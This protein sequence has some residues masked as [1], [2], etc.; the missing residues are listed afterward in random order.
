MKPSSH[1]VSSF[2]AWWTVGCSCF[3]MATHLCGQP[4]EQRIKS[5]GNFNQSSASPRARLL[6][7]TNGLLYGTTE[8]GGWEI[9]GT[10]NFSGSESG[11]VFVVSTNGTGYSV[12]HAFGPTLSDGQYPYGGL[13][14]A[15]DGNLY[16][17]TFGGGYAFHGYLGTV[18]KLDLDGTGYVV[19]YDFGT[20]I[21][22]G[23]NPTAGLVQATNGVLYGTTSTGVPNIFEIE[24]SGSNFSVASSPNVSTLTSPVAIG[25]DGMLYG[26]S[27][28]SGAGPETGYTGILFKVNPD[29]TDFTAL[30]NFTGPDGTT[31]S[32]GLLQGA[33]GSFYGIA[34]SGGSNNVGTVFQVASDG[35]SFS[36]LHVFGG[37]G[38]GQNPYGALLQ[39]LNGRLYGTTGFG[40]A[41]NMGT[42]FELTTNGTGYTVLHNFGGNSDGQNSFAG[43]TQGSDGTLYGTTFAG[44]SGGKGTVFKLSPDGN[45]YSVICDFDPGDFD[46]QFPVAALVQATNGS[47]Y[48][49]TDGGG[50]NNVGTLFR[51]DSYGANYTP[52]HNFSATGQDG[53]SPCGAMLQGADGKLY[54][55]TSAGG[56][57]NGGTAFSVEPDGS[58]YVIIYSFGNGITDGQLPMAGMIQASNGVLYG[59]CASG[60]TNGYG[61]VFEMNPDGTD[62]TILHSFAS[63]GD[64]QSPFCALALGTNGALY[65]TTVYGG[66]N[67]EG[68]IFKISLDGTGYELLYSF[69]A[70][71][72]DAP[73]PNAGLILGNDG[74]FYGTCYGGGVDS[75]SG[76]MVFRISE[77][78]S[79]YAILHTF[80]IGGNGTIILADGLYPMGALAQGNDGALYGTTQLGGAYYNGSTTAGYGTL[81]KLNPDGSQYQLLY[82]FSPGGDATCPYAGL[83]LGTNGDFYGAGMYG[84]DDGLGALFTWG[85]NALPSPELKRPTAANGVVSLSWTST[86]GRAYQTQYKTD[87]RQSYWINLGNPIWATNETAVFSDVVAGDRQRFYRIIVS[88]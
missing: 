41:S 48:G 77:D 38:D 42:I 66:T 23:N 67:N 62:Y 65:G 81:F 58:Q 28:G 9:D 5:F 10:A 88:Q 76:G 55:T 46:G 80:A 59:T 21:G 61:T 82:S 34:V 25:R 19:L 74:A 87:L 16:G 72:G 57:Y 86:A 35:S 54:G 83:T 11:T 32:A 45:N 29:G 71:A 75:S 70:T 12:L 39:G 63:D 79:Q 60:G 15:S 31:P 26:E 27:S 22:T 64:G 44:G 24:T 30:H 14:Q 7:A 56:G 53:R 43:L 50:S 8:Y 84:G 13:I 73:Y 2:V 47:F 17:T 36:V 33:D 20:G 1:Y 4:V 6:L 52:L 49:T 37:G 3:C 51:I 78:G 18:F 85:T 40:G 69:G 68:S